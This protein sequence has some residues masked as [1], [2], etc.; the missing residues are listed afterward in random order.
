MIFLA[1][2]GSIIC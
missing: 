2:P 1:Y